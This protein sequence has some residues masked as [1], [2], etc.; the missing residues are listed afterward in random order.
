MNNT[1]PVFCFANSQFE[2]QIFSKNVTNTLDPIIL[3]ILLYVIKINILPNPHILVN[4]ILLYPPLIFIRA[5]IAK[6]CTYFSSHSIFRQI[7]VMLWHLVRLVTYQFFSGRRFHVI[8]IRVGVLQRVPTL[9]KQCCRIQKVLPID[10]CST[11][12]HDFFVDSS[13]NFC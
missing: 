8:C 9:G 3:G 1:I 6:L 4:K 11:T 10:P 7:D 5:S 13:L 12:T 2:I